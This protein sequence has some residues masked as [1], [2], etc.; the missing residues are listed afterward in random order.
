VSESIWVAR[1]EAFVRESIEEPWE[2]I[3]IRA[4]RDEYGINTLVRYRCV[5]ATH[6][7]QPGYIDGLAEAFYELGEAHRP[8]ALFATC[9]F[10]LEAG[11]KYAVTF[12]Y[13]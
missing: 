9:S 13:D 5:G 6:D 8:G 11:G 7:E 4:E 12:E 1:I 3:S 2:R 10:S